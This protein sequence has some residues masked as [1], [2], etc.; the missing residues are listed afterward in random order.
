M[1]N[2]LNLNVSNC[3]LKNFAESIKERKKKHISK[4]VNCINK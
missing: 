1:L 2:H 3:L 4:L